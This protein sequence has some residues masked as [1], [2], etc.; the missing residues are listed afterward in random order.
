MNENHTN[1][2]PLAYYYYVAI[3]FTYFFGY[4]DIDTKFSLLLMMIYFR[5]RTCG[6][7]KVFSHLP[8]ALFS[9]TGVKKKALDDLLPKLLSLI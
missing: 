9:C 1:K 3:I 7:Y 5:R 8:T 4:Y 6:T 2:L